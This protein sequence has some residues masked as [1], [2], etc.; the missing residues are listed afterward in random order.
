[1]NRR[2][3]IKD[4][5]LTG[6]VLPSIILG[7]CEQ[8]TSPEATA[9]ERAPGKPESFEL[10]EMSISSLQEGMTQGKYSC[11]EITQLYLDRIRTIDKDGPS[12]NSIIE[13]NPDALSIADTL[14]Q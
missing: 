11:R 1:M 10:D 7:A 9:K 2:K 6:F 8:K 3:F 5:S 13:L 4:T 14:D 12:L